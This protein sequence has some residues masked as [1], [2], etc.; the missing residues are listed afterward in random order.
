MKRFGIGILAVVWL[1]AVGQASASGYLIYEQGAKP[2]AQAGAFVARA[3][4][5]SALYYNAAGITGLEGWNLQLGTSAIFL[6]DTTFQNASGAPEDEMNKNTAFPSHLYLTHHATDLISWGFAIY[7]PYGL[8]TEW[9]SDASTRFSS[10][11]A[12]LRTIYLNPS[13]AFSFGKGFSVAAGVSYVQGKVKAFSSNT[14]LTP[15]AALTNPTTNGQQIF[16]NLTGEGDDVTFNVGFQWKN[17]AWKVGLAY[18]GEASVEVNDGSIDFG[19]VPNAAIL[20]EPGVFLPSKFPDGD[21]AATLPLPANASAGFAYTGGKSW[22]LEFDVV[23]TDWSAFETLDI[24]FATETTVTVPLPSPP[25]PPGQFTQ[26][27]VVADRSTN[28]SWQDTYSYRVGFGYRFNDQHELR[29]GAY[30]DENPIP[31]ESVRPSLPDG[32]RISGQIGY[33]FTTSGGHFGIDAYYQYIAVDDRSIAAVPGDTSV[34]AGDYQTTIQLLGVTG[35]WK[36]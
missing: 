30:F 26:A 27:P 29:A 33:G 5:P 19:D 18:R 20:T 32:D 21:A 11:H 16:S 31:D 28:E 2:S 24:D 17:D 15:F 34:I 22:D 8:E 23:W 14:S 12:D 9:D 13:I 4:D 6:G 36:F 1:A 10:R 7:T 25:F 3:D 35:R